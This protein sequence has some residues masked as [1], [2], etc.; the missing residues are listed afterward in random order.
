MTG[1]PSRK[2]SV[3][4][5]V[6]GL[7]F[8]C[9]TTAGCGMTLYEVPVETP[10]PAKL[11]VSAFQRVLVAGFVAGGADDIDTNQETVRLLR[12]QLRSK[13]ELRVIDADVMQLVDVAQEQSKAAA[14]DNS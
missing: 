10:I 8:V 5:A 1:W 7:A 14:N 3:R 13:S 9:A 2:T 4:L 12:S 11:D 6:A